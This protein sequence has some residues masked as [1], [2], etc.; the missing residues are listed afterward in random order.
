MFLQVSVYPRGDVCLWVWGCLP[1]G[2]GVSGGVSASGFGGCLPL[3]PG[4]CLP[5]GSGGV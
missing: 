3:G 5:L 1:L 2:P 4:G